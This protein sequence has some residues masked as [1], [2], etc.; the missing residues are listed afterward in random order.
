MIKNKNENGYEK[1]CHFIAPDSYLKRVFF[2]QCTQ[3]CSISF[4][5]NLGDQYS[6]ISN[7]KEWQVEHGFGLHHIHANWVFTASA[8]HQV[9]GYVVQEGKEGGGAH[10]SPG[11]LTHHTITHPFINSFIRI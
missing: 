3:L 11:E 7:G 4:E 8:G 9:V 10:T 2:Q 6:S 5:S 1:K